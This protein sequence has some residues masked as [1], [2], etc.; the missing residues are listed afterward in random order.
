MSPSNTAVE[1]GNPPPRRKSCAA[2]GKAKRRC[3]NRQPVCVRCT[4]RKIDCIYAPAVLSGRD[5]HL[6]TPPGPGAP[7]SPTEA[8]PSP[9]PVPGVI[10]EPTALWDDELFPSAPPHIANQDQPPISDVNIDLSDFILGNGTAAVDEVLAATPSATES[11]DLIF[12]PPAP[13]MLFL[14]GKR[15]PSVTSSIIAS[16]L[17]YA[18]DSLRDAPTRM[19]LEAQT[20]WC[21]PH[22][23]KDYMPR[24]MRDAHA[25]CALY[26]SKNAANAPT[27]LRSIESH[28]DDLLAA[29]EPASPLE[30][31]A[32][33][34]A[35]LL[36]QVILIFDGDI[37]LRA[38]AAK[39]TPALDAA[40]V[41]LMAQLGVDE[42]YYA[43]TDPV[44]ETLPL[45]P[46]TKARTFWES[47][48]FT[49]SARRTFMTACMFL[50][51]YRLLSGGTPLFCNSRLHFHH[52][53]TV[54]GHL[55]DA[56]DAFEFAVAWRDKRHWVV[57]EDE[58]LQIVRDAE[59]DDID[60]FGRILFTVLL[61]IDEAKAWFAS[62]GSR[63]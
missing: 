52:S 43:K 47:W 8:S 15:N 50:Q 6:A 32:R 26:H 62:K 13:L 7:Q 17:Q 44:P 22:L 34:Q 46:L 4:Q 23:Y 40:A 45:Y 36:Y 2:C 63:F 54:S 56:G 16:R 39:T 1:R 59:A 3:D 9:F 31:L 29:S 38:S 5:R 41:A 51:L 20:P 53:L 58:F 48:V 21:H 10:D 35:L 33:V 12:S 19:V 11:P 14:F 25:C 28:V 42:L 49:E 18:I 61:G 60:A 37:Q 30:A 27:V 57:R 55:W 24:S